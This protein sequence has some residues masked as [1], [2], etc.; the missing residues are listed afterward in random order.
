[1][2]KLK[3]DNQDDINL[4]LYAGALYLHSS[5]EIFKATHQKLE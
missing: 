3:D 2:G 1:M 4:T 5:T